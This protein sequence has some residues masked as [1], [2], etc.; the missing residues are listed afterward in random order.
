MPTDNNVWKQRCTMLN[1]LA[2]KIDSGHAPEV[3]VTGTRGIPSLQF[4][5]F[6]FDRSRAT[7]HNV[8]CTMFFMA[9]ISERAG[10]GILRVA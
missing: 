7:E 8:A 1:T 5:S 3:L 6:A 2:A 9:A 4:A 10:N